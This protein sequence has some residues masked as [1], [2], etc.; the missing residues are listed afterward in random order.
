MVAFTLSHTIAMLYNQF[1]VPL[2]NCASGKWL[3]ACPISIALL[4]VACRMAIECLLSSV[5]VAYWQAGALTDHLLPIKTEKTVLQPRKLDDD[6]FQQDT[7]EVLP[8]DGK[9]QPKEPQDPKDPKDSKDPK[10]AKVR[11]ANVELPR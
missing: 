1:Q 4:S 3:H 2:V 5:F 11:A 8:D 9:D 10:K 7:K 6:L